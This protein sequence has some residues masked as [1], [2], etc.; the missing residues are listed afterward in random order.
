MEQGISKQ[1]DGLI[2]K[3]YG[4]IKP[5]NLDEWY[6]DAKD[7]MK[8]FGKKE[9]IRNFID[10]FEAVKRSFMKDPESDERKKKI[11]KLSGLIALLKSNEPDFLLESLQRKGY[12]IA[13]NDT[14]IREGIEKSIFRILQQI[15]LGKKDTV[16]GQL[17]GIFASRG[18]ALPQELVDALQAEW[19][20][21]QFR[22]FMYA[23]LS[24]FTGRE[25]YND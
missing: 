20:I 11:A 3:L 13:K 24:N 25:D 9:R 10:S 1:I 8:I 5:E 15:R 14:G 12:A 4:A 16:I 23:F 17:M 19:D 21:N 6:N 18:K 7:V 22:A 2:D